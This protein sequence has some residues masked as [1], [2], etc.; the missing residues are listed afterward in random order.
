MRELDALAEA[1]RTALG[2]WLTGREGAEVRPPGRLTFGRPETLAHAAVGAAVELRTPVDSRYPGAGAETLTDGL[3]GSGQFSDGRWLGFSGV[4]LDAVVDLGSVRRVD[5]LGLDCLQAQAPWI[6]FPQSVRFSVS[7][8][9]D[10]WAQLPAVDVPVVR[11]G[12]MKVQLFSVDAD[13]VE[14]RYVRVVASTLDGL[15]EWHGAAGE[16]AWIFVDELV[17]EAS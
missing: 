3:V 11:D 6:F 15:P 10:A 5:R 2:D 17:V 9:G 7:T 13:G 12:E 14:A 16:P 1:A 4:D 8:D